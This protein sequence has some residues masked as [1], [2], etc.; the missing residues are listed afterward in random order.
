MFAETI[1]Q[2]IAELPS[3]PSVMDKILMLSSGDDVEVDDLVEIVMSD[4]ALATRFLAIANSPLV[5]RTG[6]P[7]TDARRAIVAL[8]LRESRRMLMAHAS[9]VVDVDDRVAGYCMEDRAL[10]RYSISCAVTAAELAAIVG[11]PFPMDPYLCGLLLDVGKLVLGP[12]L[13]ER[14]DEVMQL[15]TEQGLPFDQAEASVFGMDHAEIGARAAEHWG[16]PEALVTVI[17]YHHR[18]DQ[19][20]NH[21]RL[22]H[23]VHM[24]DSFAMTFGE[25]SGA[26]G[27]R[28]RVMPSWKDHLT[29]KKA[30]MSHILLESQERIRH[31]ME[32]LHA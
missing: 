29:V 18:P 12:H 4:P 9:A 24:A 22:V 15:A 31:T 28:Y 1:L 2:D 16:L 27:F 17:R 25:H 30:D 32:V 5:N 20:P 7:V 11:G 6:K 14:F 8:G 26:D 19:A 3:P 23:L 13:S 21:Q 10:W